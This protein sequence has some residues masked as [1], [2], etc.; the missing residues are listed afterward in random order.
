MATESKRRVIDIATVSPD[1]ARLAWEVKNNHES[2]VLQHAGRD[3]VVLTP[4]AEP[5]KSRR[6]RGKPLTKDDPLFALAGSGKSG[7]PGG[8]SGHKHEFLAKAYRHR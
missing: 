1:L 8:V 7:I 5:V 2:V 4:A 6:R 3:L